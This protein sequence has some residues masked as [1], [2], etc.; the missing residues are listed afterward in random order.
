MIGQ[1]EWWTDSLPNC[2]PRFSKDSLPVECGRTC[3]IWRA[4]LIR[5]AAIS[6]T[7]GPFHVLLLDTLFHADVSF[8]W[9]VCWDFQWVAPPL[10]WRCT[11]FRLKAI[12]HQEPPKKIKPL[13]QNLCTLNC[14]KHTS[15]SVWA[16][17]ALRP[18]VIT[19]ANY[20]KKK[21]AAICCCFSMLNN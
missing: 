11:L 8:S 14:F 5:C 16:T 9:L 15:Y 21:A 3:S 13:N 12:K 2:I 17:P 7:Q 18:W 19:M 20:V 6:L 1:L 4:K 10:A